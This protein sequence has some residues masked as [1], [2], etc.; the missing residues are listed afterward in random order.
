[1]EKALNYSDIWL[2]PEYSELT[3]RSKANVRAE[4]LGRKYRL[5]VCPANMK[6]VIDMKTAKWLSENDYFYIYHRFGKTEDHPTNF[7][8]TA[9]KE[10]WKLIS[11]SIGVKEEDKCLIDG[12]LW[13]QNR[14]DIITIDVA[15]GHH[16]L[17]KEMIQ[18]IKDT[19]RKAKVQCPY[20]IAGNVCT[21]Q[22]VYDLWTWG[23][24][25]IKIGIAG[26]AACSTK[27]MTGFHIPMFSCI[28]NCT[29]DLPE[30]P[31][32]ADGGIK[33]N[34]DI[35]KALVAGASMVMAGSLFS[36]CVDSPAENIKIEGS[37][38]IIA[39]RY[40]GSASYANK[41]HNKNLEGIEIDIPCNQMTY[42]QKYQEIKQSL[43]SS[44]S[45][46]GGKNLSAFKKVKW[47]N[48]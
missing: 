42:E 19:Y 43:Q 38:I 36:A 7:V 32:I 37:D 28:K 8:R 26:G 11:I 44:I 29:Y 10:K 48:I 25:A 21:P 47:I 3:S 31:I 24:N 1:M 33:E 46:A 12:I 17:V 13:G 41:G 39:K 9:N 14:I 18:F 23:A 15:H 40:F 2:V 34:G 6:S 20:I 27:N 45:Y 22:A 4:F 5:P 35:S 16:L 30:I